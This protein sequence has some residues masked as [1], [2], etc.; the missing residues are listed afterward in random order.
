MER[1]VTGYSPGAIGRIA[2]M[3]GTYYHR[4]WKFGLFFEAKVATE[5]ADFLSI[6]DKERDGLLTIFN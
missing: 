4:H 5:I 6:F 2:E 1:I 3:H